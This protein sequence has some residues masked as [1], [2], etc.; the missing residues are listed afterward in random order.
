MSWK[1]VRLKLEY[2]ELIKI[3]GAGSNLT[4]EKK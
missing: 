4:S 2:Q 1:N 3:A